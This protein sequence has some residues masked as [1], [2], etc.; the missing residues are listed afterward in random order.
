[1]TR[2]SRTLRRAL[3]TAAVV[4]GAG[5]G[6][7]GVATAASSRGT[8][9]AGSSSATAPSGGSSSS[10]APPGAPS[11][12][13]P[14]PSTLTHGPGETLLTGTDLQK[15]TAAAEAAVPGASVVRAETDSSGAEPYE[16][17]MKKSDGSDVT[18]ELDS[19]FDAVRTVS[20]FGSGP[21]NGQG[22]GRPSAGAGA[23]P[24]GA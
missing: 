13:P 11:G 1:M 23:P 6:S 9:P 20:G 15:A 4:V 22:R 2:N 5:L 10:S 19:S 14:D 12:T 3:V 7:A 16:V 17:H 18:V 21:P 24:T 8:S